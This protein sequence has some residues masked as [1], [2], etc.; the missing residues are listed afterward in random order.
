MFPQGYNTTDQTK[1]EGDLAVVVHHTT[2][3]TNM[4]L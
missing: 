4:A 1:I 2:H 3:C